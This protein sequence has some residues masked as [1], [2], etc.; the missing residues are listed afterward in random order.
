MNHSSTLA[1]LS[2]F[3]TLSESDFTLNI[4]ESKRYVPIKRLMAII[5]RRFAIRDADTHVDLCFFNGSS[6]FVAWST[7]YSSRTHSHYA[8]VSERMCF[9]AKVVRRFRGTGSGPALRHGHRR[10]L[11]DKRDREKEIETWLCVSAREIVWLDFRRKII[12]EIYRFNILGYFRA[13]VVKGV[14]ILAKCYCVNLELESISKNF[15]IGLW[16]NFHLRFFI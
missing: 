5:R 16:K 12:R 9:R 4:L 6:M 8:G 1:Q 13:K 3:V 2:F 10:N 7:E 15:I 14:C 11:A